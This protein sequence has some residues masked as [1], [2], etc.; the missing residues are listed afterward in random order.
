[1]IVWGADRGVR[2]RQRISLSQVRSAAR[3]E[4]AASESW[5]GLRNSYYRAKRR[6]AAKKFTVYMKKQG[7]DVNLDP[8]GRYV[9]PD[10]NRSRTIRM[11]NGG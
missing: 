7:K 6:R 2:G 1:M 10:G 3:V 4:F 11:T 8:S 9:D 5:F